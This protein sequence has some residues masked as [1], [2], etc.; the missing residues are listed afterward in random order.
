MPAFDGLSKG[1]G[2]MDNIVDNSALRLAIVLVA[3]VAT[4]FLT[5]GGWYE[6][7]V[8]DSAWPKQP[9][10]V[11]PAEGG[12]NRKLFWVPANI[13]AVVAL[14]AAL[15]ASWPAPGARYAAFVAI[16]FYA[17]INAVTV[18]FFAPAVLQVEKNGVAAND[19][20]SIR[21]VRLSRWRTPLSLAVNASLIVAAIS[22]ARVL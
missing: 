8:L 11:R 21:W 22:L 7:G 9:A 2:Q 15:W 10:I 19:P 1:G 13:F 3:L 5:G 17:V 12:A 14:L 18:W 6:Q 16:G 20:T 4:A